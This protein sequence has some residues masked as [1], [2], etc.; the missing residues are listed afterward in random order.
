[1]E[2]KYLTFEGNL[3][4]TRPSFQNK[5]K[6]ERGQQKEG[7]GFSA[8]MWHLDLGSSGQGMECSVSGSSS[9]FM[10]MFSPW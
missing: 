4:Y 5:K 3:G 9:R 10:P 8:A 2:V 6:Q 7:V 1:L